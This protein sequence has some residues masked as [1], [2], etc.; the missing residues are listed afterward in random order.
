M[1]CQTRAASRPLYKLP[2]P[3]FFKISPAIL[4]GDVLV[5]ASPASY[6]LTLII[7]IG[8]ITHV[9]HIPARPPTA[10]FPSVVAREDLGAAFGAAGAGAATGLGASVV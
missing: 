6:T 9:A 4:N 3:S 8:C 2:K 10:K 5:P 1:A 7:S